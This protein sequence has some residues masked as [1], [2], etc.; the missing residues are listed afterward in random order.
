MN[1]VWNLNSIYTGFDDPAF[2][3]DLAALK[4]CVADFAAF[5]ASLGEA[6][7]ME[8]LRCGIARQE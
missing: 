6:D 5:T 2:E 7:P 3:K 1:E 8:G 4:S